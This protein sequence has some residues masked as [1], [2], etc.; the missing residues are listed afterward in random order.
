[1][2]VSEANE[3]NDSGENSTPPEDPP[4]LVRQ[5]AFR[6]LDVEDMKK[7][8][9]YHLQEELYE[10]LYTNLFNELSSLFEESRRDLQARVQDLEQ[11][12]GQVARTPLASGRM[13]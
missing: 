11:A 7:I 12:L 10:S 13:R 8:I 1:M 3:V 6:W 5:N 2:S 9:H 4:P